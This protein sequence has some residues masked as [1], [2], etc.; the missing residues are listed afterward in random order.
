MLWSADALPAL[1]ALE[2]A[3]QAGEL[4]Q[5]IEF[6]EPR[7]SFQP[8]GVGTEV[9]VAIA[10]G[11]VR[12]GKATVALP[13]AELARQMFRLAAALPPLLRHHHRPQAKNPY[14][15]ELTER[16]RE[17]LSH[18]R[19][20][21]PAAEARP[22]T[23]RKAQGR[24]APPLASAGKL[25]RLRFEP[26]WTKER[27]GGDTYGSLLASPA[28]PIF[29]S[30]PMAVG[31]SPSGELRFRRVTTGSLAVSP[32]GEVLATDGARNL[33]FAGDGPSARWFGPSDGLG[34]GPELLSADGLRLTLGEGRAVLCFSA[35]TGRELWRIA[36][37]RT[38]KVHLAV[39]GHR[40]LLATDTGQLYGVELEDGQVRYRVTAPMPC[41]R[42][43]VAW[44]RRAVLVIGR[45][46]HTGLIA[47]DA[48]SG[49]VSW[50]AQLELSRPSC[51]LARGRRLFVAG[52]RGGQG[53][54]V[55]LTSEGKL[56]WE[57]PLPQE[58][59]P[60]FLSAVDRLV[61]ASGGN[62]A[63][64]LFDPSGNLEWRVGAS[65]E[66]QFEIAPSIGRGVIVL[67]G[68]PV[69]AIDVHGGRLLGEV[70]ARP[71]LCD[72]LVDRKL[73]LY[74]L[75]DGGTLQAFHL[76]SHFAVVT[77]SGAE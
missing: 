31:L 23:R 45:R 68:N 14:L 12:V 60:Y 49:A 7:W 66:E 33:L 53:V 2:L 18:L 40:A 42:A 57:R 9:H 4:T 50:T 77:G 69:R 55:A 5:A 51:P 11:T 24:K 21:T 17:G 52:E 54:L 37:L 27:L 39:Q 26:L 28:G 73:N 10:E 62:G 76:R 75:D 30:G 44:G 34:I 64:S 25:R 74:L 6:H 56:L 3:R 22:A 13:A 20:A 16:S 43:P 41:L 8:G 63:A 47:L 19:E 61:L 48:D 59:A 71:G 70:K 46:E 36:P 38:Q 67:P 29:A 58:R 32:S 35:H 65:S 15:H 72:L 1:F